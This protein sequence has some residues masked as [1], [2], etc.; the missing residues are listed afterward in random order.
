M[1]KMIGAMVVYGF[2]L[3]GVVESADWLPQRAQP[4]TVAITSGASCPDRMVDE[5][6]DRVISLFPT[7]HSLAAWVEQ[8]IAHRV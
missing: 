8:Y 4:V 5:V 1:F 6:I 7:A 2:A 3:Y